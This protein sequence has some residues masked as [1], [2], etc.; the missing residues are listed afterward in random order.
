MRREVDLER[1]RI[2]VRPVAIGTLVGF[3][4]VMLPLVGLEV[5][6]L[7]ES[8]FT[9]GM[10][11]L[12]R[13]VSRVDS[14]VLLEVGELAEG[15]LAVGTVVGLD[16]QVDAQVLRQVGGVGKGLGAMGALMRLGLGVRLGVDLHLRLGEEGKRAD[17][18]PVRLPFFADVSRG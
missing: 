3:V 8:L 18:T 15:L 13:S 12:V 4:F 9:A 5:R 16:T 6:E 11:A 2:R 10:R 17:F 14:G 7:C 1:S